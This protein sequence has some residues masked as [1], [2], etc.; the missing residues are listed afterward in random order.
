M[1]YHPEEF[2]FPRMSRIELRGKTNNIL[3]YVDCGNISED[4]KTG[5]KNISENMQK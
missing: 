1:L 3:P 2:D 4:A 5:S